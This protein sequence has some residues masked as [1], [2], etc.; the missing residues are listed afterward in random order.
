[1]GGMRLAR[2]SLLVPIVPAVAAPPAVADDASVVAA[3][4]AR[5]A[6]DLPAAMG[7][8]ARAVRRFMRSFSDRAAR[9]VIRAD[10][11]LNE[12]LRRIRGEVAAQA[13]SSPRGDDGRGLALREIR[14]WRQANLLEVRGLRAN[15]AGR[16]A[17]A[18]RYVR[19]AT[20]TFNHADVLGSRAV[21]AFRDAGHPPPHGSVID[22]QPR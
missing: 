14:G 12:V 1:V 21:R 3:Y 11:R 9:S 15:I 10:R 18:R 16:H 8:Y 13:A 22:G 20:R 7:Q 2:A 5:Q 17:R 19:R 6:T 4:D